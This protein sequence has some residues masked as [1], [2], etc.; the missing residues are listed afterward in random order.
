MAV[1]D[2]LRY[3]TDSPQTDFPGLGVNPDLIPLDRLRIRAQLTFLKADSLSDRAVAAKYLFDRIAEYY[4]VAGY[5]CPYL[6]KYSE[7]GTCLCEWIV[8]PRYEPWRVKR[9]FGGANDWADPEKVF[10]TVRFMCIESALRLAAWEASREVPE[11]EK[12]LQYAAWLVRATIVER[13]GGAWRNIRARYGTKRM[14]DTILA[15]KANIAEMEVVASNHWGGR[16]VDR[17]PRL[18][19]L[20]TA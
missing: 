4:L 8:E 20:K 9:I 19:K 1:N 2:K 13:C 11:S 17:S 18:A 7:M 5:V 15:V 12:A 14:R 10:N 3:R 16:F 6:S